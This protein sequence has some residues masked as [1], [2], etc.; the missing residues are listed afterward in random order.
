MKNPKFK[1]ITILALAL[2]LV[3]YGLGKHVGAGGFLPGSKEDPLVSKSYVDHHLT[4]KIGEMSRQVA[5]LSRQIAELEKQLGCA[6][7]GPGV[8]GTGNIIKLTVGNG[9]A[10]IGGIA[11]KLDVPPVIQSGYTLIP[12]RFVGEALGATFDYN[13]QTKT[14][15][16]K[17]AAHRVTLKIGQ[18]SA[19]VDGKEVKLDMPARISAGRTLVPLRFVGES[20][21]ANVD[22]NN[23]T[24]TVTVTR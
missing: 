2:L 3:G 14:I 19:D 8:P 4:A 13:S 5:D 22:W 9:T 21:G 11:H 16:F 12:L 17:T 18:K 23:A 15:V 20:L 6:S 10:Y 7:P 24:K 1:Y